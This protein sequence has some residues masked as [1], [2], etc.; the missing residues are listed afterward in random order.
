MYNQQQKNMAEIIVAI[1]EAIE[2]IGFDIWGDRNNG[3]TQ[4]RI[5]IRH[6]QNLEDVLQFLSGDEEF[7]VIEVDQTKL[8]G[9]YFSHRVIIFGGSSY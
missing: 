1:T 7:E 8:S 9:R 4:M 2:K 5:D 3:Y 6:D